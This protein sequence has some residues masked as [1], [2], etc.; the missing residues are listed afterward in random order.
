MVVE[1]LS[2][3]LGARCFGET[4]IEDVAT[5]EV[6][7]VRKERWLEEHRLA[8]LIDI[9]LKELSME[10]FVEGRQNIAIK[11][12]MLKY[13]VR[14]FVLVCQCW[15]VQHVIAHDVGIRPESVDNLSPK[16]EEL[17]LV[18]I[19]I[20]VESLEAT[21]NLRRAIKHVEWS[22]QT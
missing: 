18:A 7:R 20:L 16:V 5:A 17:V 2:A 21:D 14:V 4:H 10:A 8:K 9:S 15:L 19:D 12:L 3:K 1:H 6:H 13:Q 22:V 11:F